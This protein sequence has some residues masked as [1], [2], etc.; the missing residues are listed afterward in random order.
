M[1][2]QKVCQRG[3]NFDVVYFGFFWGGFTLI[4]IRGSKY[5]YK[6]AII[7][8][9]ANAIIMAFHWPAYNDQHHSV[10]LEY[11]MTIKCVKLFRNVLMKKI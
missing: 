5:Y 2:I 4:L 11:L 6:L 10:S 9:P 1:R 8:P 3:S 7:D